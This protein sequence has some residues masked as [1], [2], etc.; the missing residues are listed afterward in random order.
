VAAPPY[1]GRD[2]PP[3]PVPQWIN[4]DGLKRLRPP[5]PAPHK[6]SP[7]SEDGEEDSD[8]TPEQREGDRWFYRQSRDREQRIDQY[9]KEQRQQSDKKW[10]EQKERM[11][12]QRRQYNKEMQ[13]K[14]REREEER[15]R[16]EERWREEDRRR[17]EEDLRRSHSVAAQ[18]V[19]RRELPPP[20][21]LPPVEPPI[22]GDQLQPKR[23]QWFDKRGELRNELRSE[24][25]M[26]QLPR[27]DDIEHQQLERRREIREVERERR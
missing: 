10:Q 26:R 9:Q 21:P 12:E 16:Q 11:D 6:V 20:E 15:R 25:E 13:E 3:P 2:T 5:P 22:E 4:K 8:I 19:E 18:P 1:P 23:E 14:M 24:E 27:A 17:R 7:P